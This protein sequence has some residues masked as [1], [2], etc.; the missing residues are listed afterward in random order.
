MRARRL[1]AVPGRSTAIRLFFCTPGRRALE[2]LRVTGCSDR[3]KG[4]P[5]K[6][7]TQLRSANQELTPVAATGR[8]APLATM[9]RVL[10]GGL[11]EVRSE[12]CNRGRGLPEKR[13]RSGDEPVSGLRHYEGKEK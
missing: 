7:R 1:L 8:E 2:R 9:R 12:R 5:R 3:E 4:G 10:L 11:R 13:R 6:A